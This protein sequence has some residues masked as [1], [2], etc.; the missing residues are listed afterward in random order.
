M[1]KTKASI[2]PRFVLAIIKELI[3]RRREEEEILVEVDE[4]FGD[5]I[6]AFFGEEKPRPKIV[7]DEVMSL[8]E[9]GVS[10]WDSSRDI[11]EISGIEE[12]PDDELEEEVDEPE[13]RPRAPQRTKLSERGRKPPPHSKMHV[14]DR[15]Q[16]RGRAR[17][18]IVVALL[19]VIAL[20]FGSVVCLF[21]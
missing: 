21:L 17:S 9:L 14:E 3:E 5:Q 2:K 11:D 4:I 10:S 20:T 6:D 16:E 13:I 19:V 8:S 18:I 12:I 1:T 15:W 7:V